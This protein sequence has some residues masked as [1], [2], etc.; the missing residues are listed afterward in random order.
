MDR[1]RMDRDRWAVPAGGLHERGWARREEQVR[2]ERDR[3]PESRG[4]RRGAERAR[5]PFDARTARAQL[6]EWARRRDELARASRPQMVPDRHCDAERHGLDRDMRDMREGLIVVRITQE[7]RRA[8]ER[9]W[10]DSNGE[11][12][13]SLL[14]H[15][16]KLDDRS[17]ERRAQERI[18]GLLGS[19]LEASN[20]RGRGHVAERP[21][22]PD[23]YDRR[24][25]F[26]EPRRDGFDPRRNPYGDTCWHDTFHRNYMAT[27]ERELE[28]ARDIGL[29][30]DRA[31][32]EAHKR[33]SG[34]AAD[35]A[36]RTWD[37]HEFDRRDSPTLEAEERRSARRKALLV[38]AER[39]ERERH[40][41]APDTPEERVRHEW[42]M[43]RLD[44]DWQREEERH[45]REVYRL[46]GYV[47][48][49]EEWQ[50]ERDAEESRR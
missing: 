45:R 40:A 41:S 20:E 44:A 33:A 37:A 16:L 47:D 13:N 8:R 6:E 25:G 4:D 18:R 7:L 22:S 46:R 2:G 49:M 50:A 48:A 26:R 29:P 32:V 14:G 12:S 42:E 21:E 5:E 43:A 3:L 31:R 9:P 23:E 28:R 15:L 19:W 30:E 34:V 17:R 11:F 38:E 39:R 27:Y 35:E 36:D 1:D 10:W 24:I